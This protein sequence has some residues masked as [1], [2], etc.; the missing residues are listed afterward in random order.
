MQTCVVIYINIYTH[1]GGNKG[2]KDGYS[3][4]GSYILVS[5]A[6][7]VGTISCCLASDVI[8]IFSIGR[9]RLDREE[10]ELHVLCSREKGR[11]RRGERATEGYHI[12]LIPFSFDHVDF[13]ST[14]THTKP[15]QLPNCRIL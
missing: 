8:S 2:S 14:H 10:E 5:E 1:E 3:A 11:E 9:G 12:F 6:G 15:L 4:S 13:I 7:R